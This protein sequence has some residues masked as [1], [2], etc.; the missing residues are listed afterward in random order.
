MIAALWL[1]VLLGPGYA[2]AQPPAHI[3]AAHEFLM[4]WGKG[5][6]EALKA[7]TAGKVTVKVAG[8]EYTLDA[9]AR[10]ADAQLVFP[11]RGLSSVREEGKVT[12]ITVEQIAVQAG[13]QEKKGRAT[14]TLQEQGG[15]FT[16]TGVSIE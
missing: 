13:G 1:A 10:K 6:W 12:A 15:T 4:G 2:W 16:V 3:Q 7:R 11:F 8:A 9:D 5:D 14:V